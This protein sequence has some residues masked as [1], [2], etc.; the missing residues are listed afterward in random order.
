VKGFVRRQEERLAVRLLEWRYQ[1][2]NMPLP[3]KDELERHAAGIVDDAH[4]I[5]RERGRNVMSIIKEMV[6]DIKKR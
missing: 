4:R 2:M 6:A 3:S 5:A 1:K